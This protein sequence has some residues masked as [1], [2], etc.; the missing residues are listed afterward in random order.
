MSER[1]VPVSKIPSLAEAPPDARITFDYELP[2]KLDQ[3]RICVDMRNLGLIQRSARIWQNSITEHT[4]KTTEYSPNVLGISLDGAALFGL[5]GSVKRAE[6]GKGSIQDPPGVSARS[7]LNS[8]PTRVI[9]SFNKPEI[10]ERFRDKTSSIRGR[11]NQERSMANE[12]SEAFTESM[13]APLRAHLLNQGRLSSNEASNALLRSMTSSLAAGGFLGMDLIN[14]SPRT[15]STIFTVAAFYLAG[16]VYS[17]YDNPGPPVFDRLRARRW[18]ITPVDT[19][20]DRWLAS[21]M[22]STLKVFKARK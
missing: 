10:N 18:S 20:P 13:S 7:M 2:S 15:P 19:Q 8:Y 1:F 14:M 11:K 3:D 16:I 5:G 21:N 12:L 6:R 22:L 4:G 9:N 17:E